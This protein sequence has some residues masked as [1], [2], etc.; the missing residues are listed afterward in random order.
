MSLYDPGGGRRG[1]SGKGAGQAYGEIK[2]VFFP[3]QYLQNFSVSDQNPGVAA[4][5]KH[6]LARGQKKK[7]FI[8]RSSVMDYNQIDGSTHARM[9]ATQK[10]CKL[11]RRIR[12]L[13]R[14]FS[15]DDDQIRRIIVGSASCIT[16]I[17]TELSFPFCKNLVSRPV[18]LFRRN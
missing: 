15:A 7:N 3:Y 1:G 14:T 2:F 4:T 18:T 13:R 9:H 17:F 5:I 10:Y 8:R 16:Q 11:F 6:V 12:V